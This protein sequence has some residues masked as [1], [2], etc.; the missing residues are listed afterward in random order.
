MVARIPAVHSHLLCLGLLSTHLCAC[1][2]DGDGLATSS[3]ASLEA[4][5]ADADNA[6]RN[7]EAGAP[8][9]SDADAPPKGRSDA[10]ASDGGGAFCGR[11][12]HCDDYCRKVQSAQCPADAPL[13]SCRQ[14]CASPELAECARED[15][16]LL[17]CRAALPQSAFGC[18]PDFGLVIAS[19]CRAEIEALQAC[20]PDL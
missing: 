6:A 2:R 11:R 18:D 7:R 3:D 9:M 15:G 8:S 13:S 14:Q 19:G 20:H 10:A 5:A 1:G 16:A 17:A 12:C 4:D